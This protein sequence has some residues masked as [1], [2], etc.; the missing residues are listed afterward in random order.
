[1]TPCPRELKKRYQ[2]GRLLPFIGA[3][4][5]MSFSWKDLQGNLV[6][7]PSWEQLV[8]RAATELGFS[9]AELARVRG[10]DQQ[11]LEYFKIKQ[12]NEIAKL[13]NW[14]ASQMTPPDD[15]L[16]H[17]ALHKELSKLKRCKKFYT[18]NY[19]NFLERAFK[20]NGR[21]VH[22]SAIES[23][24][25][26]DD[27]E[28]EVVKFHGDLEHPNQIVLTESDYEQRL[29]FATPMDYRLRSDLLGRVIL[30]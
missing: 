6:R 3:G 17:S 12:G 19:D 7:G 9:V 30:F 22:V 29:R 13:T 14:L 15:D 24:L 11:I 25:G 5:S 16:K 23:Q 27:H 26:I 18:T 10:T 4:A 21:S 28:C 20:L 8:N 1:M 2:E